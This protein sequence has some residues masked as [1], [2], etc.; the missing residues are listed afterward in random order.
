MIDVQDSGVTGEAESSQANIGI[1]QR[2]GPMVVDD[3]YGGSTEDSHGLPNLN[4][5][6]GRGGGKVKHKKSTAG[7]SSGS[8]GM[9]SEISP[10][11]ASRQR[12]GK[13]ASKNQSKLAWQLQHR[14]SAP[15]NTTQF[16]L[17]EHKG[18]SPEVTMDSFAD[19]DQSLISQKSGAVGAYSSYGFEK[20]YEK[21]LFSD[22]KNKDKDELLNHIRELQNEIEELRTENHHLRR[23]KK[24]MEREDGTTM[25]SSME[26]S[27]ALRRNS[28]FYVESSTSAG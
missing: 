22:L 27:E 2:L 10:S 7:V 8:G 28:E 16:I 9:D 23:D 6:R 18:V 17:D 20:N 24:S 21:S 11:R 19:D 25:M 12:A 5:R 3:T 13:R 1:Q 14:P 15:Q 4:G 26:L